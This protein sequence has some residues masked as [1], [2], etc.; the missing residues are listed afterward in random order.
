MSIESELRAELRDAMKSGDTARRD[1]IRQIETEA[2]VARAAPGAG[3]EDGDEL[4][5]RVIA[6]Y[7]KKMTKAAEEYRGLGER[8]RPMAERLAFEVDYL[9]RWLPATLDEDQTRAL[10]D[11]AIAEL[12][13]GGDPKAVGRVVGR[14]MSAHRDE[15][16]GALVNRL[17]R[18]AL[19]H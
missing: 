18:R 2:A 15:V 3:G 4:Y 1:V 6:G 12:G 17:A 9:S 11:R 5:R 8:G 13:V 14:V 7:V 10:V 16:D 19:E